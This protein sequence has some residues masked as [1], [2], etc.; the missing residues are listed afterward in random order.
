VF[1]STSILALALVSCA[2]SK[3][4]AAPAGPAIGTVVPL[5]GDRVRATGVVA[6]YPVPG[7]GKVHSEWALYSALGSETASPGVIAALIPMPADTLGGP[8]RV[9][10]DA[11]APFDGQ[12]VTVEGTM[13]QRP[14]RRRQS[15]PWPRLAVASITTA[16]P[17][18]QARVMW[19]GALVQPG[20]WFDEPW[21]YNLVQAHELMLAEQR[22]GG[23]YRDLAAAEKA[24]GSRIPAP[25]SPMAGRLVGVLLVGPPKRTW[26]LVYSSGLVVSGPQG[27]MNEGTA[28]IY[29][30]L[31]DRSSSKERLVHVNGRPGFIGEM[32]GLGPGVLTHYSV[33]T[34]YIFFWD[35][36]QVVGI[37]Y[38]GL[39]S[40]PSDDELIAIA[41]S[42]SPR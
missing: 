18:A 3:P 39:G 15:S 5:A 37:V 13:T 26:R 16:P 36:T 28:W 11:L 12:L 9:A 29:S 7:M 25:A 24:H 30:T 20:R 6:R 38:R 27:R 17:E 40:G 19:K 1:L 21:R 14:A 2:P 35:G 42:M 31:N 41:A 8:G 33:L 4:A 22:G 10:T 23:G 32:N 34:H